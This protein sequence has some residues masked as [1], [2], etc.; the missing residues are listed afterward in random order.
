MFIGRIFNQRH[1]WGI[2]FLIISLLPLFI[3]YER[4]WFLTLCFALFCIGITLVC[5]YFAEKISN[6]SLLQM[7]LS[8][9]KYKFNYF[10]IGL[11]G[12]LILEAYVSYFGG[13]WYYPFFETWNYIVIA[14]LMGG[15]GAY[16]LAII[17]SYY[18]VKVLLDKINKGTKRINPNQN[19]YKFLFSGLGIL[20]L[21]GLIYTFNEIAIG[22]NYFQEFAFNINERKDPYISFET[23]LIAFLSVWFIFEAVE[24]FRHR[25]SI[26]IDTLNGYFVPIIAILIS[27]IS[28]ALY[29]ELQNSY[30]D[31]WIYVNF[32]LE[33]IRVL[34]LP[35][36]MY[37][38]W[39]LHYIGFISLYRAFG[40]PPSAELL[41]GDNI[42]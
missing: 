14:I 17:S 32:P 16:F 33:N 24:F 27:S 18:F 8:N 36:L 12:G 22:T 40:D 26:L 11:I 3:E 5:D 29:M 30:I 23:V 4:A 21:G 6:R 35:L 19:K 31:L 10:F 20:G 42:K 38:S 15:F 28:L 25:N 34:N 2:G 39:P 9:N 1:Y 41:A 7:I 13:L 37:L